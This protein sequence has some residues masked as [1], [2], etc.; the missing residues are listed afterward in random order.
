[1][2]LPLKEKQEDFSSIKTVKFGGSKNPAWKKKSDASL[3]GYRETPGKSTHTLWI[4]KH[5]HMCTLSL[6]FLVANKLWN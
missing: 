3:K 4:A 1:M 6:F 2:Y 5:T